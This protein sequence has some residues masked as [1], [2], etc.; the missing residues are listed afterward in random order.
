MAGESDPEEIIRSVPKG[1][2]C[3]NFGGG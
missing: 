1:L 2:Y 3:V